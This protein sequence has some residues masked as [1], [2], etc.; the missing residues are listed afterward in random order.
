MSTAVYLDQIRQLVELQKV[1]DA[2]F[3][4]RQELESAPRQLDEL[5]R[6]C[7][8][9]AGIERFAASSALPNTR[10]WSGV[11]STS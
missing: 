11:A 8:I 3:A 5:Q 7:A 9:A 2:I 4:V 1:D 6:Y 10:A